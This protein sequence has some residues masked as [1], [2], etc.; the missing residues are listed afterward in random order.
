MPDLNQT[1]GRYNEEG[2]A[3]ESNDWLNTIED[4]LMEATASQLS[5]GLCSIIYCRILNRVGA[6]LYAYT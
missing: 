4:W 5:H 1:I 6:T 2:N 3:M